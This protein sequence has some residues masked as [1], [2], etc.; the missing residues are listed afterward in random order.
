MWG[1]RRITQKLVLEWYPPREDL[2]GSFSGSATPEY[3][4]TPLHEL[5]NQMTKGSSLALHIRQLS[6]TVRLLWFSEE[7]PEHLTLSCPVS[8]E[9]GLEALHFPFFTNLCVKWKKLT[10][11]TSPD[12]G[13][14]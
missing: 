1:L 6:I 12:A 13:I 14:D 7:K 8:S 2:S 3:V 9:V 5:E 10:L 4:G 11:V